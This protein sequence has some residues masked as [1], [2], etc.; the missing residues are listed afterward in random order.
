MPI[1]I[2]LPGGETAVLRDDADMTNRDVKALR[3]AA[4]I[5]SGIVNR[6][7][8]FGFDENDPDTWTSFA[9]LSEEDAESLDLFQR[10]CV[11]TR[12]QSWTLGRDLPKTVDEVDDLPR[13]IYA[14]ITGAATKINL[15]DDFGVENAANPSVA[16]GDS[17]N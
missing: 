14:A 4:R 13:P 1:T 17:V 9:E 7:K 2:D 5:A 8:A 11:V 10:Q 15:A 6:L 12:L 16:T 3:R